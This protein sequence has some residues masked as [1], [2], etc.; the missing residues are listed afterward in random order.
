MNP[1][2]P[3]SKRTH[4]TGPA[5]AVAAELLVVFAG[6]LGVIGLLHDYRGF[7]DPAF[8]G[9]ESLLLKYIGAILVTGG[10]GLLMFRRR[11]NRR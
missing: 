4:R 7:A 2:Q 5:F 6:A 9:R 8:A 1:G 11:R 3:V 10:H